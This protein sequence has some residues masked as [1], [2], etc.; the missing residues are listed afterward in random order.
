MT[1]NYFIGYYLA[2]HKESFVL[3]KREI[4]N[5]SV[6]SFS[7]K[8]FGRELFYVEKSCLIDSVALQDLEIKK[9]L[10]NSSVPLYLVKTKDIGN[11]V[12]NEL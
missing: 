5:Y 12:L 7:N 11:V 2:L 4:D 9:V 8:V 3:E 6:V 1:L 10:F